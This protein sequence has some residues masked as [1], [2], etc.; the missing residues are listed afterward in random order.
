M[1][2]SNS[3]VDS[4][5]AEKTKLKLTENELLVLNTH[6]AQ[7]REASGQDRK[8]ILKTVI[9]EAKVH[10]PQMDAGLLRKR[11]V[12]SFSYSTSNFVH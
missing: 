12:V 4:P 11:K 2:R 7:W 6:L 3:L 10:A 9:K 8:N 1:P 5:Q